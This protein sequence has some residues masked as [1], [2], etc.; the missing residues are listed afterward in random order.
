MLRPADRWLMPTTSNPLFFGKWHTSQSIK[1][2]GTFAF[3]RM[4]IT[5]MLAFCMQSSTSGRKM[6]PS[7]PCF[8]KRLATD[9]TIWARFAVVPP[10]SWPRNTEQPDFS[11]AT[12]TSCAKRWKNGVSVIS[13]IKRPIRPVLTVV[14]LKW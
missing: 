11:A 1:T 8:T 7:T 3:R 14:V 9:F 13:G 12:E 4:S 6:T 10:A 5:A 2:T